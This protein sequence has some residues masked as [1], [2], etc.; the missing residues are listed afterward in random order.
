MHHDIE[1]EHIF[2]VLGARMPGFQANGFAKQQHR[3]IHAGL[4]KLQEYLQACRTG[5]RDLQRSEVHEIMESFGGVLWKHLDAE[6]EEL[7]AQNMRKYWTLK[8]MKT[9]LAMF[10]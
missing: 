3:L 4:D 2:P 9:R 1:E 6:V 8:D 10:G 5:E 7:R